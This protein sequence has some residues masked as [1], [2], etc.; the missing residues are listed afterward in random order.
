[1]AVPKSLIA[2]PQRENQVSSHSPPAR[3]HGVRG[4][5]VSVKRRVGKK[6]L[7][8][9]KIEEACQKKGQVISG[10]KG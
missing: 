6:G 10:G 2:P 3:L 8:L 5:L 4:L 7:I 9:H 1:M